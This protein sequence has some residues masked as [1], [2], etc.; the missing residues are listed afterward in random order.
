MS[1]ILPIYHQFTYFSLQFI[2]CDHSV[3]WCVIPGT[4]CVLCVTSSNLEAI[5]GCVRCRMH[6]CVYVCTI[7]FTKYSAISVDFIFL[8]NGRNWHTR[9]FLHP[10]NLVG[11]QHH[12]HGLPGS[13]NPYHIHYNVK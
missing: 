9:L 1:K 4:N 6:N 11:R 10:S 12:H 5:Y 2:R 3:F 13:A 8:S 7:I